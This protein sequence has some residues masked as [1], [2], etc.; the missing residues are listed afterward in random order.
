M[1]SKLLTRQ[2]GNRKLCS[3]FIFHF[4]PALVQSPSP[5][6]AS[7]DAVAFCFKHLEQEVHDWGP[8]AVM[9]EVYS[10][11]LKLWVAPRSTWYWSLRDLGCHGFS[12]KGSVSVISM[13]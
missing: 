5:P 10:G 9:T 4:T 6:L 13:S 1:T 8:I 7:A 12:N 3:P 11:S 2:T